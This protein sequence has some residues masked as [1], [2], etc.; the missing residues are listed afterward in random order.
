[1]NILEIARDCGF[2]PTDH[3]DYNYCNEDQLNTFAQAVID[4]YKAGLVPVAYM[5]ERI[6]SVESFPAKR[7]PKIYDK[8]WWRFTPLY[9]LKETK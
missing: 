6:G 8:S 9:A 1:M 3:A 7:I 4:D 2:T 5:Q